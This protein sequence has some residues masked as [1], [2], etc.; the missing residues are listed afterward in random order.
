MVLSWS[1][2]IHDEACTEVE[3]YIG[4]DRERYVQRKRTRR[5]RERERWRERD[6]QTD[7]QKDRQT[8]RQTDRQ[9]DREG[10][11]RDGEKE[12]GGRGERYI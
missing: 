3:I 11:I 2:P 9:T 12:I 1:K 4:R 6:R 7:R 10:G 5:E 8:Y